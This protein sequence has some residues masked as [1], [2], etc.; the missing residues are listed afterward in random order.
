MVQ[1][2]IQLFYNGETG[3]KDI[4]L[5]TNVAMIKVEV[6]GDGPLT[7][8]AMLDRESQQYTLGAIKSDDFSKNTTLTNGLY[9]VEV[10]GYYKIFFNLAGNADVYIK[11]IC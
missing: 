3:Q 4:I 5:K 6:K 7:I 1:R 2:Y 9:T 11:T 10:S 8:S